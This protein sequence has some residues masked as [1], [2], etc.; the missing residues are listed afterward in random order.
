MVT[1]VALSNQNV[2][3]LLRKWFDQT[4]TIFPDNKHTPA[5]LG[6]RKSFNVF[7]S[8]EIVGAEGGI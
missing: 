7:A 4:M 5:Q 3:Q 8:Q 2:E 6:L 1:R